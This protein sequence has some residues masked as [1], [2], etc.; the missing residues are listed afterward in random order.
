L[1][2]ILQRVLEASVSIDGLQY[3]SI[4]KGLLAYV[5][6]ESGDNQNSINKF[7]DKVSRYKIFKGDSSNLDTSLAQLDAALLIVSQFTLSASTNKGL[8]PSYHLALEPSQAKNL[9]D[10]MIETSKHLSIRVFFGEFGASM[11]VSSINDGPYTLI[12]NF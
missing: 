7:F 1:K 11:Q 10:L 2:V 5:C 6:F 12:Y 8:K 9:F 3:S 4:K